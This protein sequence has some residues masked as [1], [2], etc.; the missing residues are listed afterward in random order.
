MIVLNLLLI[1]I[2]IVFCI[3]Y[4]GFIEE[5][6]ILITK[7]LKS[8]IKY[9]IPKPFSCSTC[10]S[11]WL[12][13][14]YLIL[15]KHFTVIYLAV[16]VLISALTPELLQLIHFVKGLISRIIICIEHYTGIE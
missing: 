16:V 11:F 12:G 2:I 3:D 1:G 7:L 13:I 14:V 6:E 10:L 8:P 4:S 5:M 15:T 9:H